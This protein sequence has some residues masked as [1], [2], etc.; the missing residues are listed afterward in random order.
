M[1]P[2]YNFQDYQQKPSNQMVAK[3]QVASAQHSILS[4]KMFHRQRLAWLLQSSLFFLCI[5]FYWNSL[6]CEFVFD[7]I[8]A[9]RDNKD[10]RPHV[11]LKNLLKNDFWGTSMTKEQSH[12]SYRPLTVLTF[13]W[14]YAI[15]GL[16]PTGYHLVRILL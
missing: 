10:L 1:L 8:S 15:G 14:N 13:R 5:A 3:Q 9:I 12:K 2:F 7:D 4:E 6:E 16:N 11:P